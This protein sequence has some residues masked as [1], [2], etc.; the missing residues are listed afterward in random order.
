MTDRYLSENSLSSLPVGVF[1]SLT[2]LQR[3]YVPITRIVPC[4][5]L[6]NRSNTWVATRCPMQIWIVGRMVLMAMLGRRLDCNSLSSLPEGVF[7]NLMA[8]QTLYVSIMTS[9]ATHSTQPKRESCKLLV[10]QNACFFADCT[11]TT[12]LH[13]VNHQRPVVQF[14]EHR[15]SRNCF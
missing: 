6:V 10:M 7:N 3:L 14:G 2:T 13:V 1:N 15:M 9:R 4:D 5:V 11:P 8:L 12:K